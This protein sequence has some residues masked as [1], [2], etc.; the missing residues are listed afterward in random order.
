M[1]VVSSLYVMFIYHKFIYV[2]SHYLIEY[3]YVVLSRD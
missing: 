3:V 2:V 1:V